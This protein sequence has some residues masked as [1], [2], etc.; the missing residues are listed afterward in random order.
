MEPEGSLCVHNGPPLVPILSQMTPVHTLP[1]YLPKI[2]SNINFS[3]TPSNSKWSLHFK[4]VLK[5]SRNLS[6]R[7]WKTT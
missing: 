4:I 7:L 3:Y 6:Q 2:N 5:Y 1:T